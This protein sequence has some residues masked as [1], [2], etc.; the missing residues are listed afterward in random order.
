MLAALAKIR[1]NCSETEFQKTLEVVRENIIFKGNPIGRS[2][3]KAFPKPLNSDVVYTVEDILK[4]I[5]HFAPKIDTLVQLLKTTFETAGRFEFEETIALCRT[6]IENE[7]VSIALLRVL[8]FV[9]NHAPNGSAIVQTVDGILTQ[10][11]TK[12]VRY[13]SLAIRELSSPKTDYFSICDKI[14][15]SEES[16][17]IWIAKSFIDHIPRS[18]DVFVKTLSAYYSISIF[19]AFLYYACVQ[20]TEHPLLNQFPPLVSSLSGIYKELDTVQLKPTLFYKGAEDFLGME[21]FRETFLLIEIAECFRYKTIHGSIFSRA[22]EK[23]SNRVPLEKT[24]LGGYFHGINSIA[25][26]GDEKRT[27]DISSHKYQKNCSCYFEKSNALVYVL[28]RKDG[29]VG[30]EELE[31]VRLM[32]VTRE[33]GNICPQQ[34]IESIRLQAKTDE[35]RLVASCLSFI[36]EKSQLK[37]HELRGVIQDI[38]IRKFQSKT[39]HLL[40]YMYEISPSVT[41]H[42]IQTCDETFLSKL[43]QLIQNPNRAIEERATI[44][45]WYGNKI[46]DPAYLERAKNLRIDVQINK[47]K[48]TIDDSRIY[49]DPVKFTQ[50]VTDQALNPITILLDSLL[51]NKDAVVLSVNWERVKTGITLDDQLGAMLLLCYEE[52]CSNKIYGIASYLGRRIRHGTLK[53]TGLTDVKN[54]GIHPK[55]ARLFANKEF[56]DAY[57]SW[58]QDYEK[59][60][61]Q[62]RD[63]YLHIQ[64]KNKPDGLIIKDFRSANKKLIATHLMQDVI[65]SFS[66]NKNG[67]ELPYIVTEYCWRLIEEDLVIIRKFLMETKAKVAVFRVENL[68]KQREVQEF[69]QELN[70][71]TAEK[72]RVISSWFNKP[73]IASPSADIV[74]LFNAVVSEIKGFFKDYTPEIQVNEFS[75]PISGGLYF[76]IYD[77]LYILIYN[78]ARYGNEKGSL[79]MNAALEEV[80]SNKNIKITISSQIPEGEKMSDVE[81]FIDTALKGDFEDALIVEGRSG[82]KKL[83]RMEHDNYIGSVEYMFDK[84]T[85]HASFNFKVDYQS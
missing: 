27:F 49:V 54:F 76:V 74:L 28:E 43:F 35:L 48:G 4:K 77:A 78:A 17:L 20:R 82:I 38:T 51:S 29:Q 24:L 13:L 53:G 23:E 47:Q 32:S 30:E 64:E 42:L 62:L 26:I 67:L 57:S 37:E 81:S 14:N 61:D 3:N 46:S 71:L 70:S 8:Y 45:E 11:K 80:D 10:V 6:L 59:T 9:R 63:H 40:D 79:H 2:F 31:F 58:L 44:L 21:F 68:M 36:K 85:V 1:K 22:E 12:N 15:A 18:T 52:F 66:H 33:I 16:S 50:W 34:Y 60:L 7:G 69:C 25:D 65:K 5:E 19:D 83:K 75:I 55:H 72:F 39:P 73:S 84:D 41:E 56:S